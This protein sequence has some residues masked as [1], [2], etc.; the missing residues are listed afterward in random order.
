MKQSGD[1]GEEAI[2]VSHRDAKDRYIKKQSR[3]N[4]LLGIGVG[5]VYRRAVLFLHTKSSAERTID[6][7]IQE[8][9]I[10]RV[11]TLLATGKFNEAVEG[12]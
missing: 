8:E 4:I 3:K 5:A 6:A 11:D 2:I 1:Y 12:T 9:T 7:S 10:T